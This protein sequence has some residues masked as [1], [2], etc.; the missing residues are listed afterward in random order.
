MFCMGEYTN[1]RFQSMIILICFMLASI[2]ILYFSPV[3]YFCIVGLVNSRFQKLIHATSYLLFTFFICTW[4]K[5][6]PWSVLTIQFF[7]SPCI[8]KFPQKNLEL[9]DSSH[10]LVMQV[11]QYFFLHSFL[12]VYLSMPKL[13]NFLRYFLQPQ[14]LLV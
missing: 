14:H 9:L 5:D 10:S 13:R 7:Q 11:L 6:R 1:T 8:T 4:C 2:W 12:L 3:L